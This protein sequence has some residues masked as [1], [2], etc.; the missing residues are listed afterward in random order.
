M[1]PDALAVALTDG[2]RRDLKSQLDDD[3]DPL[4]ESVTI[5]LENASRRRK[6]T[7]RSDGVHSRDL[8]RQIWPPVADTAE[9]DSL[10]CVTSHLSTDD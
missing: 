1:V 6:R 10:K 7:A 4:F 3:L 9:M 8:H 5:D 2:E